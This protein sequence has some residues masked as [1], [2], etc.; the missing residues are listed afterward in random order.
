MNRQ[1]REGFDRAATASAQVAACVLHGQFAPKA[2]TFTA[3]AEL[4]QGFHNSARRA[5]ETIGESDV[6]AYAGVCTGSNG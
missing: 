4:A 6:T 3:I 5:L 1:E 2:P